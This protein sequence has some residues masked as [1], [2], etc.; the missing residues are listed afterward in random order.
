VTVPYPV[1]RW[2]TPEYR[3]QIDCINATLRT[4]VIAVP[5]V[6]VLDVHEQLCP[7]GACKRDLPGIGPIRPDGVHFSIDG[8]RGTAA[9]V[10]EQIQ[11]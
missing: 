11:R 9:W 4:S 7:H 6:R 8:A 1:G 3:D 5:S 10:L 2:D